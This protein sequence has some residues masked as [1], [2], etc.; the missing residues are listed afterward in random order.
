MSEQTLIL[1]K[2]DG[3]QRGLMGEILSRIEAKGYEFKELKMLQAT[4]EQLAQHYQDLF[5]K[6]FY[7]S[8]E[9]Y[10]TSGPVVAA[11]VEGVRVVEG[12]RSLSG[13]TDPTAAA[14][15]TIRGD[16]GRAWDD[17]IFNLI[18][19]SD[20]PASAER[21]IAIWFPEKN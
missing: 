1:V 7:P 5:T 3:L 21:E 10:M 6:P 18:H 17:G 9:E 4:P 11:I 2:P 19:S 8:I 15:G 13:V 16:F 14:P 20:S 12:V